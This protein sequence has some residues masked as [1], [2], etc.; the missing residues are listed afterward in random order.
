MSL[1]LYAAENIQHLSELRPVESPEPGMFENF[2][3][4]TARVT[5]RGFAQVGSALDLAGAPLA[6]LQD[7]IMGSGTEAQDRYF[8][9]H[10][11]A[12]GSAIEHWT[13]RPG[14]V[15][16]AA[17]VVGGLLSTLPL[18]I[19]APELAVAS[20]QLGTAEELVKKGVSPEKAQIVGA[21][22]GAGLGLGIWMPILG[23]NGWQRVA[24][25]GMGFNLGQGVVMR[26][27]SG[28]VL[29]GT[30]A[31][32]DFK[33]FDGK[34]MTLDA[35]LGL[36]F[37][38]MS[39]LSPTQRAQ[40]EKAWTRIRDW[41][42][43]LEPSTVDAAIVLRQAEHKNVD[44]AP[45]KLTEP[46][47]IQ[48]HVQRVDAA[49]EQ[50]AR[51]ERVAVDDRPAPRADPDPAR[52]REAESRA[53]Q[54][55]KESE[56][57]GK[58]YD[59]VLEQ[60]VGPSNDPVVRLTPK[61]IGDVLVER[62]PAFQKQGSAEMKIGGFGLVKFIWKHGEKSKTHAAL[63]T[64]REDVMRAPEVLRDYLPI[65][66]VRQDDGRHLREWQV[67]R[68]DGKKVI[69]ATSKFT[70]SD[71]EHHLVTVFVNE[72]KTGKQQNKPLS[73]KRNRQTESPDVASTAS[74]GD[75]GPGSS[76]VVPPGGQK[77]G[78]GIVGTE[79][80]A[81]QPRGTE[82]PPPRGSAGEKPAG[83][84]ASKDP[85]IAEAQSIAAE[86]PELALR[87]GENAGGEPIVTTA[88]D[89]MDAAAADAN[90]LRDQAKLI[91]IAAQCLLGRS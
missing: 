89:F 9:E 54:L 14:E 34:A 42:S 1:D 44:S 26:G 72:G 32:Q 11:E 18:A 75:T 65:S 71:G 66:D 48:A 8:R 6:V 36:A 25:G 38:T 46:T 60:P 30:P 77:G 27:A 41:A 43:G 63:Q 84:E 57:L 58:A 35:L 87:T 56:A 37:G 76:S 52:W 91:A 19:A 74:G 10:D 22:Q 40:G 4:G 70:E 45:G 67:E 16:V 53:E 28:A 69:Y 78:E 20:A 73:E 49:L 31:A 47:D 3:P 12:F 81:G 50:L 86:R 85:L 90:G 7:K 59:I 23:R 88:K 80:P 24:V 15:G 62:G 21:I 55:Q 29:Q 39:H 13:P 83:A 79:A 51:D 33:A 64:T 82:P 61:E 2:V 5:M 68:A 17:E